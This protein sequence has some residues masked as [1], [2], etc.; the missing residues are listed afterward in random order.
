MNSDGEKMP[1]DAPEPRV[2][3]VASSFEREEDEQEAAT[4]AESP[5]RTSKNRRVTDAFDV[6]VTRQLHDRTCDEDADAEH[7][8]HVTEIFAFREC[9]CSKKSSAA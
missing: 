2:S 6:V 1:P 9:R 8:D 3:E 5:D 7:S 4:P